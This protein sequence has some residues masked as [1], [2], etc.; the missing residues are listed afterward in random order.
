[1]RINPRSLAIVGVDL[2]PGDD[3]VVVYKS[4]CITFP[5]IVKDLLKGCRPII[6]MG[7]CHPKSISGGCL[8]SAFSKDDTNQ[9]FP[10]AY[11]TMR[12]ECEESWS[13]IIKLLMESTEV[14][15]VEGWTFI[16]NKQKV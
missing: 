8:L 4:I 3:N 11:A 5:S 15:N 12:A 16:T 14:E 6:G 7:G 10:V 2:V 13:L 1:M 9:M